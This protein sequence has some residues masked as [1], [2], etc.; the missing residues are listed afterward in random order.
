M[1]IKNLQ[2]IFFIE[3]TKKFESKPPR[4]FDHGSN[5]KTR[6][7]NIFIYDFENLIIYHSLTTQQ[8][9]KQGVLIKIIF[10]Q[11]AKIQVSTYCNMKKKHIMIKCIVYSN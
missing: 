10:Q 5:T 1:W 2:L 6:H 4:I 3:Q 11:V 8:H 9:S 7:H